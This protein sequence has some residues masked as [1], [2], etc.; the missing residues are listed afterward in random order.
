[1]LNRLLLLL[2]LSLFSMVLGCSVNATDSNLNSETAQDDLLRGLTATDESPGF[3]DPGL[4]AQATGEENFDDPILSQ[5]QA[6]ELLGD[7]ESDLY[8]IR[9]VWGRL[10]LNNTVSEA[11]S[12]DEAT[13]VCEATDWSGS[14]SVNRG[15]EIIRRVI[16]FEANHD[17]ILPRADRRLIEWEST[18]TEH[19]DGIAVDI[20]IPPPIPVIDTLEIINVT[21]EN[22]TVVTMVVDITYPKEDPVEVVFETGPFSST[23]TLD[24]ISA[25][26]TIVYLDDGNTLALHGL[27]LDHTPC[28][29][30]FL[31]GE[32]SHTE[33]NEN[34]F[35]DLRITSSGLVTGY[36]RGTYGETENGEELFRGKWISTTG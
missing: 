20:L 16:R 29:L 10:C 21:P 6:D 5:A 26:D 27:K 30:G 23:F 31:A 11:T 14:I 34:V 8:H 28:P 36:I 12:V 33:D 32:W 25:L 19:N 15:A 17:L 7:D 24:E 13:Y 9:I 1:M 2:V 3:N 18:T 22:D 4:L 35:R